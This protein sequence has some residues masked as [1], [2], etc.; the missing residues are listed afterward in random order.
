VRRELVAVDEVAQGPQRA[1]VQAGGQLHHE[2]GDAKARQREQRRTAQ[3]DGEID[4]LNAP[5]RPRRRTLRRRGRERRHGRVQQELRRRDHRLRRQEL[6]LHDHELGPERL[7]RLQRLVLARVVGGPVRESFRR[8]WS[9]VRRRVRV[10]DLTHERARERCGSDRSGILAERAHVHVTSFFQALRRRRWTVEGVAD[11]LTKFFR[12]RSSKMSCLLSIVVP[13][14][15]EEQ[16]LP[17]FLTT[18]RPVLAEVTEDYEIIFVADPCTDRTVE[19]I[20]EEH[21]RDPR[22]KLLLYSRRFGQPAATIG[23]MTFATGEAIIPIDCDLQDPPR[24]I[25]EMVRLWRAGNKV[26]IPQRTSRE[27]EN[28]IKRMVAYVGYWVINRIAIVPI[29]RNT[30]DFRLLDRRVAREIVKLQES[31]GFL[32]GLTSIV[33]FKTVLVPFDRDAR[34]GGKGKY[35]RLTG[36]LKIGFNGI[37]AFSDSLLRLM[38]VV[39]ISM[40]ALALFAVPVVA[41]AKAYN[42]YRFAQGLATMCILMLFLGGVQLVGMGLLGAYVGRTY[43]ETKRRPK[44]IIDEALGLPRPAEDA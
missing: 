1:R 33:G 34:V 41:L 37:V 39:G 3:E 21:E 32:R 35:N 16:T 43:E 17:K 36:S 40:A 20:R 28:L 44:F 2:R 15:N 5:A 14:Y 22:V 13:V 31:H 4:P 30:G 25:P 11:R 12:P 8:R 23:G 38:V 18:I 42:V 29:P 24:L 26:V 27:G 10:G 9:D 19:L 6:A 7:Q